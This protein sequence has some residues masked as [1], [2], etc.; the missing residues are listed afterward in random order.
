M[1]FALALLYSIAPIPPLVSAQVI[2]SASPSGTVVPP[3]A[4]I[5]D[6]AGNIWALG[7]ASPDGGYDFPIL[8]NGIQAAYGVG[9]LLYYGNGGLYT[10]N[11]TFQTWY[12]WTGLSWQ[13]VASPLSNPLP[14]PPSPTPAPAPSPGPSS[15][16]PVGTTLPP[17][18]QIIDQ[19]GNVWTL[20]TSSPDGG[21]DF[22]ILENGI[23][24]GY[25]VGGN[26]LLQRECLH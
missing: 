2:Q 21:Y 4:Q 5:V 18:T 12:L 26:S 16:S 23:Q 17:A 3:A 10:E 15:P 19:A 14:A 7:T 6:Q 24:A 11:L 9:G 8:E 13:N 20:G 1:S 22:P 25:G